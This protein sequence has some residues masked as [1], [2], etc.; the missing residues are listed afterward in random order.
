M[1]AGVLKTM[2]MAGIA[3][4]VTATPAMAAPAASCALKPADQ[5]VALN[6]IENLMGRYG[7]LGTLRG[8]GTLEELFAMK[9]PGVSWKTPGGP[10]GIEAMKARF[11]DP[12]E[13]RRPGI[14]H[15][16][17]MFSPVIEVA[18]DG[19]TAKGVWDS[20]GPTISGPDDEGG[21]LMVKYAVDFA[22]QDDG[23]KI[24]HLQVYPVFSTKYHTSITQTAREMAARP[25]GPMV[26]G[27]SGRDSPRAGAPGGARAG[28]PPQA[29]PGYV[30]PEHI[31]RYDGK[32]AP[33]GPFIPVAYCHFD[34]ATAY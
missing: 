10:S 5:I 18:G 27:V 29:R 32:S 8:E 16:H 1:R 17:T 34:P 20:F 7:H 3:A 6:A 31:W 22:K 28:G 15:M 12:D 23:W 30:M 11:A 24:W 14:L 33:Q 26:A 13:D 19:K 9:T 2:A 21:W 4:A 25:Q